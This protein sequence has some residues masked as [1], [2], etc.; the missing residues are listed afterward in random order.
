MGGFAAGRHPSELTGDDSLPH[1][2]I[3]LA[4]D[5]PGPETLRRLEEAVEELDLRQ[6]L[7]PSLLELVDKGHVD[8][9]QLD[10]NRIPQLKSVLSRVA[11]VRQ[12]IQLSLDLD[13][14]AR[15]S[16]SRYRP[17]VW[18]AALQ[19]WFVPQSYQFDR[20]SAGGVRCTLQVEGRP[21][22][23]VLVVRP[24][25]RLLSGGLWRLV[26]RNPSTSGVPWRA[27][28]GGGAWLRQGFPAAG[29]PEPVGLDG[30]GPGA[31]SGRGGCARA[32]AG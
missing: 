9:L 4:A 12:P 2:Q 29:L 5:S 27:G 15:I 20:M 26:D 24:C 22:E 23:D 1:F 10:G 8:K 30:Q 31:P 3:V 7:P 16:E 19:Q 17:A 6:V 18:S 28:G 32:G 11:R 14:P 25:I 21:K 13:L